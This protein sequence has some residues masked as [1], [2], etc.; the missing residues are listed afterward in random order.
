[1]KKIKI[2]I[3]VLVI[4]NCNVYSQQ[5]PYSFFSQ[6]ENF[7]IVKWLWSQRII[8]LTDL[9]DK[10]SGST[11]IVGINR[12]SIKDIEKF[13]SNIDPITNIKY[14]G[15]LCLLVNNYNVFCDIVGEII[16]IE[17]Y[18]KNDTDV[19]FSPIFYNNSYSRIE[20]NKSLSAIF[21]CISNYGWD[22]NKVKIIKIEDYKAFFV[23]YDGITYVPNEPAYTT[24]LK[25]TDYFSETEFTK[26]Y[27][28][29]NFLR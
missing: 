11:K 18:H 9:Y 28:E 21:N 22:I 24:L 5:I 4:L 2:L 7:K 10:I 29:R 19:G 8:R 16:N 25:F 12:V 14:D 27:I 13:S 20:F 23:I 17:S 1:M 6:D 26:D 15:T 3:A